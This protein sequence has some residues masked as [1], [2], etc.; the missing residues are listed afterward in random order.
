MLTCA[1]R[2]ICFLLLA[3]PVVTSAE[4]P[5]EPVLPADGFEAGW[6]RAEKTRTF[7]KNDL[8][9]HIDGGAELFLEFGFE[10]LRVNK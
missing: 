8:Y 4:S 5:T 6:T 3:L 10:K 7:Y 9:G 2:V 1:V